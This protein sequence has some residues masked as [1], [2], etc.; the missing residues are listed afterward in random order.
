MERRLGTLLWLLWVQ[1]C[2]VRGLQVEQ[3]LSAQTPQEGTSHTLRC[4][5]SDIVTNMQW[6][7][8]NPGGS[9][10]NLF[11]LASETKQ[12]GRL[13]ST[14]NSKERYSTLHITTT[15]LEDS[16]TY[17]CAAQA[18]CSQAVCSLN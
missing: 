11:N 4:N 5:F 7:L 18:Q 13:K 1:I 2:S 16:G 8:Q 17:F 12:K 10:I 6:F 14:L 3:S 15:R 9:L